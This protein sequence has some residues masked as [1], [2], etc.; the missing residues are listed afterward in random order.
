M[1]LI[2]MLKSYLLNKEGLKTFK[3]NEK[4]WCFIAPTFHCVFNLC[5]QRTLQFTN[6]ECLSRC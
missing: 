1:Q 6:T 4:I 5:R 2:L 3:K